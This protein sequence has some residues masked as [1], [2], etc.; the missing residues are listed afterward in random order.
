M[1]F[2]IGATRDQKR[3]AIKHFSVAGLPVKTIAEIVKVNKKTVVKWR[4]RETANELGRSG[5]PST[6]TPQEKETITALCRDEWNVSVRKLAKELEIRQVDQNIK[7]KSPSTIG[8]FIRSTD[9][10][11][12]AYKVQVR[13]MMTEKNVA[14]RMEFCTLLS[15]LGYCEASPHGRMLVD[16]ILFTDESIVELF[17]RP[18]VQNTRIRTSFPNL[19]RPQQIPKNG[20]KIMVAGGMSARGL[21]KLHV[22]DS[23]A[24]VDGDYYRAR[25][26]PIYEEAAS[27]T[28]HYNSITA[29]RMFS[30]QRA[31]V[32]MQDGAPAHTARATLTLLDQKFSMVWS[33]GIWPGNSPDL[34]PIEHLWPI[35]QD[36]VLQEP[37]PRNRQ[38]LVQR[39]EDTWSLISL[40]LLQRLVYSFPRRVESCIENNGG[41]TI[42]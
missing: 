32:L 9:W 36:S 2:F 35:L 19:R 10:G 41:R 28:A 8:R 4:A 31:I 12:V 21:T 39:V 7:T 13:P 26:V 16:H 42:Y 27:R 1:S 11:R 3:A 15:R 33:K 5:R 38:E 18:N 34:N 14:D 23:D 29:T 20:L 24:T 30:D 40:D 6:L 37:K 17:P 22:V 25:I